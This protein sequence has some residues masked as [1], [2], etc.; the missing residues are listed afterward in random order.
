MGPDL[1]TQELDLYYNEEV[2]KVIVMRI[3]VRLLA[4]L[5]GGGNMCYPS[6]LRG[7]YRNPYLIVCSSLCHC[8]TPVG[9]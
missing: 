3:M 1:G 2:V 5:H 7:T 4:N 6:Y 8:T 9:P